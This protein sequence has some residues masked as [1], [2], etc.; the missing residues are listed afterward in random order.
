[1][2]CGVVVED[3]A[4]CDDVS[5]GI[6]VVAWGIAA[7]SVDNVVSIK[8][9]VSCGNV[10]STGTV[11]SVAVIVIGAVVSSKVVSDVVNNVVS[12][13]ETVVRIVFSV[14]LSLFLFKRRGVFYNGYQRSCK[15]IR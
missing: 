1:M 13:R 2:T 7:A 11:V 5:V 9:V 12:S 3:I 6:I 8:I 10:V 15:K 14:M 4:V